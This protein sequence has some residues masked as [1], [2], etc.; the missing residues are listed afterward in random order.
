MKLQQRKRE[1]ERLILRPLQPDD[2]DSYRHS[3]NENHPSIYTTPVVRKS[4]V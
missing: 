1:T 2:F 3:R 4:A